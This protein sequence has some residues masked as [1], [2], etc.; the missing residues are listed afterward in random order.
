MQPSVHVF[1]TGIW[2]VG[3]EFIRNAVGQGVRLRQ[4]LGVSVPGTAAKEKRI[5]GRIA[6]LMLADVRIVGATSGVT[7]TRAK[8]ALLATLRTPHCAGCAGS[9]LGSPN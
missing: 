5:N 9:T 3:R 7:M 6:Q 1:S 8:C 4:V 2:H